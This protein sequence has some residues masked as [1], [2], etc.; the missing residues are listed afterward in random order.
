MSIL[1]RPNYELVNNHVRTLLI[2][3]ISLH[4]FQQ[5]PPCLNGMPC[6]IK[7]NFIA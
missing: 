5:K 6:N 2:H 1:Y 4:V 3:T 7:L